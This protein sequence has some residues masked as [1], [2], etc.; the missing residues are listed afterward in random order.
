MK[1]QKA[2]S[3]LATF[4]PL[5]LGRFDFDTPYSLLIEVWNLE[6]DNPIAVLLQQV[7]ELETKLLYLK[8]KILVRSTFF[9]TAFLTGLDLEDFLS[10][11]AARTLLEHFSEMHT[12]LM[13]LFTEILPP[14]FEKEAVINRSSTLVYRVID[15]PD[16]EDDSTKPDTIR[17]NL[18]SCIESCGQC[19]YSKFYYYCRHNHRAIST[20][21]FIDK[22]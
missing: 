11:Q 21:K 18:K 20:A 4:D 12:V 1:C 16:E 22:I 5:C 17:K 6:E 7:L 15:R 9:E 14:R 19:T 8:D 2:G 13:D 10:D 3:Y